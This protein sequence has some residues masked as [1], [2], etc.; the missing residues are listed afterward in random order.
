MH[1]YCAYKPYCAHKHV[2][3]LSALCCKDGLRHCSSQQHRMGQQ[4]HVS[5]PDR[6]CCVCCPAVLLCRTSMTGPSGGCCRLQQLLPTLLPLPMLVATRC[7]PVVAMASS[8]PTVSTPTSQRCTCKGLRSACGCLWVTA[9]ELHVS[10]CADAA[11][12]V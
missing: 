10:K 8:M 7:L 9:A 4:T 3:V 5:T 6:M 1:P 12:V 11:W 2:R